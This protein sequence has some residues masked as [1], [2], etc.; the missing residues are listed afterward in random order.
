MAFKYW[1]FIL[2]YLIISLGK[3]DAT[4]YKDLI[5]KVLHHP[6]FDP[7]RSLGQP[8]MVS[9]G[10]AE[11][12]MKKQMCEPRRQGVETLKRHRGEHGDD[13]YESKRSC[14]AGQLNEDE[15]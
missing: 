3:L 4:F 13:S 12:R 5:Q 7:D 9:V 2:N 8:R 6:D 14:Q 10:E 15:Q 1:E 11:A